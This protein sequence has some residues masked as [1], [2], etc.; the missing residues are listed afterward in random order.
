MF[1]IKMIFKK[2]ENFTTMIE[3]DPKKGLSFLKKIAKFWKCHPPVNRNNPFK[4][5]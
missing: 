1:L 2:S 4:F 3:C 5:N